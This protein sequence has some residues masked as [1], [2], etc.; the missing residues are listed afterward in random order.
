ML[1][2]IYLQVYFALLVDDTL[3]LH[4]RIDMDKIIPAQLGSSAVTNSNI[5]N[6]KG[7]APLLSLASL[8][9]AVAYPPEFGAYVLDPTRG[10]SPASDCLSYDSSI[11][12]YN[13]DLSSLNSM[14]N[15]DATRSFFMAYETGDTSTMLNRFSFGSW[16]EVTLYRNYLDDLVD[17]FLVRNAT[18]DII[19]L[20]SLMDKNM[21]NTASYLN[22]TLPLDITTRVMAS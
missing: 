12:I 10:N 17:H 4:N 20:A 7:V 14:M 5:I 11:D 2:M 1:K 18:Y 8:N 9:E 19:A 13:R 6:I 22:S 3:E 16:E 21:N 15:T